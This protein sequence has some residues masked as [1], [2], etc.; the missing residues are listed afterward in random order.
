[1]KNEGVVVTDSDHLSSDKL[2]A[3][4]P[5]QDENGVDLS[6]IRENLRLS[7]AERLRKGDQ[8]RRGALRLMQ[9]GRQHRQRQTRRAE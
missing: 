1:M 4:F 6:L 7:P 9:L 2:A 8:S 3:P 5:E